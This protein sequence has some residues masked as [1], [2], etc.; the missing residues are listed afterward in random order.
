MLINYCLTVQYLSGST[1][2]DS[3]HITDQL[4]SF[5][6]VIVQTDSSRLVGHVNQVG[7]RLVFIKGFRW[8]G[9]GV[10][11]NYYQLIDG[12]FALKKKA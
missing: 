11:N 5:K 2:A 3:Q 7:W 4:N 1:L 10:G 9:F 8:L 12:G 6:A